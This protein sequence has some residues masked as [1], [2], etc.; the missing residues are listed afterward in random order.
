MDRNNRWKWR[1]CAWIQ[2]RVS[3]FFLKGDYS[4]FSG[5]EGKEVSL[6]LWEM[7]RTTDQQDLLPFGVKLTRSLM[8]LWNLGSDYNSPLMQRF[9]LFTSIW[10]FSELGFLRKLRSA[11][12]CL[13]CSHCK[14]RKPR[15][16]FQIFVF[17]VGIWNHSFNAIESPIIS[18]GNNWMVCGWQYA[19]L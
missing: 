6:K 16:I 9:R 19:E 7:F 8:L 2:Y 12:I 11:D 15:F 4:M 18:L 17:L 14:S 13:V 1:I 5:K 3:A 10:Y